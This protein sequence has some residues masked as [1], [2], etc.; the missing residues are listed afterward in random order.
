MYLL[1]TNIILE[2]LLNQEKADEVEKFLRNIPLETLHL[3]EFSL[4]SIG[5]ILLHRGMAEIFSRMID[6]LLVSG[7]I[8]LV[9]LGLW[10]MPNLV[11]IAQRFNLDFDDAYQY[12]VAEKYELTIVSFDGDF[13]R[14][15]LG[16]KTPT[17]IL[18]ELSENVPNLEIQNQ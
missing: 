9:R 17:E 1:D 4:Y 6:D 13:D 12:I 10:D 8:Q 5:I 15:E 14:T 2:F 11:Q 16:R 18:I 3:S 7:G